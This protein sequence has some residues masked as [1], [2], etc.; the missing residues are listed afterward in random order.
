MSGSGETTLNINVQRLTAVQS[1]SHFWVRVVPPHPQSFYTTAKPETRRHGPLPIYRLLVA[2][3]ECFQ[4]ARQA[5][6]LEVGLH[7]VH[8]FH[9]NPPNF[10]PNKSTA[11]RTKALAGGATVT[12]SGSGADSNPCCR[13]PLMVL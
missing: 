6:L 3:F 5:K 4:N 12:G 7:L 13:M 8:Q 9:D 1:Q 2:R 10:C 11:L